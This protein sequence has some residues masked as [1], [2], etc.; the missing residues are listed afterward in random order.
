MKREGETMS[1]IVANTTIALDAEQYNDFVRCLTNLKE[2]CN[3]VTI[4]DG[5]IRQRTNGNTSIFEIDLT[6]IVQNMS[7]SITDLKT[8]LDLL[9]TFQGQDVDVDITEAGNGELGY[10]TFRDQYSSIKIVLPTPEFVD[11]KYMTDEELRSIFNSSEDDL[12][13]EHDL[14]QLITDRISA[15][16]TNFNIETICVEFNEEGASLI[17]ATQSKDQVAKFISNIETNIEIPR[18]SAFISVIPFK[19]DHDTDVEFKMYVCVTYII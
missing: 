6:P 12:I 17:A 9:K 4:R 15:I 7:I 1:T 5:M 8:K 16:T 3:D 13:L 2:V 14:S 18:S 19:I 10:F 11:N